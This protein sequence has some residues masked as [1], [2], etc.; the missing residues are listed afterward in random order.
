MNL[1]IG[2]LL[3]S[4][5]G[6]GIIHKIPWDNIAIILNT[7]A[8]QKATLKYPNKTSAIKQDQLQSA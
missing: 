2:S 4:E 8:L 1:D 5:E 3:A 6:V 7:G